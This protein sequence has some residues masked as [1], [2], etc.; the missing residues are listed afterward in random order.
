VDCISPSLVVLELSIG[1]TRFPARSRWGDYMF[2]ILTKKSL[3]RA[4]PKHGLLVLSKRTLKG[5]VA[6]CE[7]PTQKV[8]DG[9][10]S[11]MFPRQIIA[12]AICRFSL[13]I[14]A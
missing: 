9:T 8:G 13:T 2:L 11:L 6:M 3:H 5:I 1:L 10:G 14:F 12:V 7:L 4:S